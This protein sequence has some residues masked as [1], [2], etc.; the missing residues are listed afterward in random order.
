MK[1]N[2]TKSNGRNSRKTRRKA[3]ASKSKRPAKPYSEMT[4][5]E[6]REATKEFDREFI[7]KTFRPATPAE[8][9]RFDRARKRGRPRIGKGSK[10]IAVTVERSLL[11]KTDRLAKKLQV[12]RAVLIARGL[13]AVLDG[14]VPVGG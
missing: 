1:N 14:E 11:T 12:P 8:R 7:G 9:A 5:A 10:T 13:Q 6:L 4:T 2:R 3:P